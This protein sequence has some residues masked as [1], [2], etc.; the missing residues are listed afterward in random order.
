[1]KAAYI[2][3]TGS[4]DV[5]RWGEVA[6][7]EPAEG[8]VLVRVEAVAVNPID[9][10]IR[11]GA[12]AMDLPQPFI[13]GCDLAGVVERVGPASAVSNRGPACG[14]RT[15]VCSGGRGPSRNSPRSMP[16][17]STAC[18]IRLR[19]RMRRPSP[20]SRSRRTSACFATPS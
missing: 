2:L 9:T 12:V 16:F 3:E 7:P 10:Y 4:P 1:M 15:R 8:Q 14:V 13:I 17:G 5:I 18:P 19:R 6:C 20:W 11:G